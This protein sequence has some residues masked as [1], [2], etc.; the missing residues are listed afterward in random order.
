MSFP[1]ISRLRDRARA[2]P[3]RIALPEGTERRTLQAAFRM[4][5]EGV[6]VPVLVG[7]EDKVTKAA[8]EAGVSLDGIAVRSTRDSER[9][10]DR[11]YEITRHRGTSRDEALQAVRDPIT[12][13]ALMVL[14]G[15][16]DGY[17][18]GAEHTTAD[19][20]RPAL[21]VLGTEVGVR[22]VSSFFL[23]VLPEGRGEFI[24]AD[25]GVIPD[26]SAAELVEIALLAAANARRF[27]ETEP[28]VALLSFSTKGSAKHPRAKKVA[29]AAETLKVRAP[30]LLAD[31]EL[32]VDA[33][34][35][36]EVAQKKAPGSRVGG[37]AN[38]LIF[39]DLDSGNIAYKLVERMAG[40][41][42]LGPILQGLARPA[43]DLSRG[44][45]VEDIVNVA[46]I[47]SLQVEGE[48]SART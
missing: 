26:P 19:T 24:F 5:A 30:E 31:G 39:P 1:F 46:A 12:F 6:A 14:E 23:M 10:A 4:K 38:T 16:A 18:A 20:V 25:C 44:C 7:A 17:V 43:N 41:A 40:A 11:Y 9:F 42:A 27:L 28:R 15:E 3:K 47:T 13:A 32:Q 33:A 35:L 29:E 45:S 22:L 8:Q 2:H 48:P 21:R 36:P 37:R 34:L